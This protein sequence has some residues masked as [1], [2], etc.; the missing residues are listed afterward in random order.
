MNGFCRDAMLRCGDR[1]DEGE[2]GGVFRMRKAVL[3]KRQVF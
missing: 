2:G 3:I 1:E